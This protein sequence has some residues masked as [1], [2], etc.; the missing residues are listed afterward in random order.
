MV[1]QPQVHRGPPSVET[2]HVGETRMEGPNTDDGDA[3]TVD[4]G[5]GEE[6]EFIY[7]VHDE[8]WSHPFNK[9][10]FKIQKASGKA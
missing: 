1:R 6:T 9:I 3:S 8:G 5:S 7:K 2:F 10:Y 4:L